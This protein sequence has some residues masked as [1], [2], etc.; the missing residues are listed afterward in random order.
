MK[1]TLPLFILLF[2]STYS[3]GQKKTNNYQQL[4]QKEFF[5]PGDTVIKFRGLLTAPN[6]TSK[7]A[8][9]VDT[10]A[11]KGN[12]N[13]IPALNDSIAFGNVKFKSIFL[14][15][16]NDRKVV[17]VGLTKSY[18]KKNGNYTTEYIHQEY[19]QLV[20]YLDGQLKLPS[21]TYDHPSRMFKKDGKTPIP[22]SNKGLTWK[23]ENVSY[24]LYLSEPLQIDST[25]KYFG[26]INLNAWRTN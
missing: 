2:L 14:Q 19:D 15:T 10:I 11:R 21:T 13:F 16:N 6:D 4:I 17:I 3:Y 22:H 5:N 25:T 7:E 18:F 24:R 26:S 12:F 9:N 8:I 23:K 20:A 1:Y